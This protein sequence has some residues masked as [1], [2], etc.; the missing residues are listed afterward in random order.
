MTIA[1]PRDEVF[2]TVESFALNGSVAD[3]TKVYAHSEYDG[4]SDEE[5]VLEGKNMELSKI[6]WNAP[7]DVTLCLKQGITGTFRSK[8]ILIVRGTP[9][10][11]KYIDNHLQEHC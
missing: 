9:E 7:D 5:L 11:F 8:V 6:V 10:A 3:D 4:K 2:Y 1:S